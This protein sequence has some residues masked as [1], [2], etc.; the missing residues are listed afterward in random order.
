MY[1]F[2]ILYVTLKIVLVGRLKYQ[3][4]NQ[5]AVIKGSILSLFRVVLRNIDKKKLP[6]Y[7]KVENI[8]GKFIRLENNI[9][10]VA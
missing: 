4:T 7:R 2:Y 10:F 6:I 5:P 1:S 3:F 9:N 8:T